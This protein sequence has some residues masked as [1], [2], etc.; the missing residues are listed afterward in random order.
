[1]SGLIDKIKC[2]VN[3]YEQDKNKFDENF[4]NNIETCI[5]EY[6][7]HNNNYKC[8][9]CSYIS[10]CKCK[11]VEYMTNEEIDNVLHSIR[12]NVDFIIPYKIPSFELM[13]SLDDRIIKRWIEL[14]KK[15][16]TN[17]QLLY[18]VSHSLCDTE[19]VIWLIDK[20]FTATSFNTAS[21]AKNG[22]LE[23]LK[24][25]H[26]KKLDFNMYTA[27]EAV[28]VNRL[29]ILTWLFDNNLINVKLCDTF[30]HCKD[31]LLAT[32]VR[33]NNIEILEYLKNKNITFRVPY[34][35]N[36]KWNLKDDQPNQKVKNTTLL[37]LWNNGYTWSKEIAHEC[38]NSFM[39]S[40]FD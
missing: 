5:K 20:G 21:F 29:D 35:S 4:I 31:D 10:N 24:Y 17:L 8:V 33:V 12:G 14:D 28:A 38:G 15:I 22:N 18:Y 13:K 40:F 16:H 11:P 30:Y 27:K 25:Y 2:L 7:T 37:W 19:Y 6:K 36:N 1:M 39:K 9:L 26:S 23:L 32:A 34:Y 3:T